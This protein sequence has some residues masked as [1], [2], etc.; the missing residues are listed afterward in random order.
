MNRSELMKKLE[1][2]GVE[3]CGTSE[4]FGL[5]EGGVWV[6]LES[7]ALAKFCLSYSVEGTEAFYNSEINKTIEV[8]GYFLENYDGGT[9]MIWKS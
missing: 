5:I 1:K 3:V 6:S 9:A 7:G 2:M 8:A 4:E